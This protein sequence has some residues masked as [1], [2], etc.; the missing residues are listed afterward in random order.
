MLLAAPAPTPTALFTLALASAAPIFS[1]PVNFESGPVLFKAPIAISGHRRWPR[2]YVS[3]RLSPSRSARRLSDCADIEDERL[4]FSSP[5]QYFLNIG[6]VLTVG[7]VAP[8]NA[9]LAGAVARAEEVAVCGS[10]PP[11]DQRLGPPTKTPQ[12]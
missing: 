3:S 8:S 9:N 11:T 4:N 6:F 10:L 1:E 5:E 12:G 2:T 7:G